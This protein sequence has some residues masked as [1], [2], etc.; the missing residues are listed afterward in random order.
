MNFREKMIR[1]TTKHQKMGWVLFILY[2]ALLVY[3]LFFAESFG[4]TDNS[5]SGY[6]YNLIPF[7][8]IMRFWTY[9]EKLG[10][11]AVA[12]NIAGN[13]AAFVPAGFFLP[14]VSLRSRRWMNTVITGFLFSLF[15]ESVQL[16][17]KVGSFD[18]DDMI[19]N[20]VGAAIGYMMYTAVQQMRIWRRCHG[21][22]KKAK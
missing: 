15:V 10:M 19:L 13:V 11:R 6:S 7:K 3:F 12:L 5:R 22:R 8:E 14:V 16:V 2:L 21:R 20:T 18:V 9:R 1:K 17:S 4:R